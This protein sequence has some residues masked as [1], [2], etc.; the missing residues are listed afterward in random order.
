MRRTA[1]P[2]DGNR[3]RSEREFLRTAPVPGAH[4]KARQPGGS[5]RDA[6]SNLGGAYH[7]QGR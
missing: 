5:P 3:I 1:G 7:P 4:F 2:V 6:D